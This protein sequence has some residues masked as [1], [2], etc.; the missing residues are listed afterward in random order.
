MTRLDKHPVMLSSQPRDRKAAPVADRLWL[1]L[2]ACAS[3]TGCLFDRDTY[4]DRKAVFADADGDGFDVASGDCDDHN[5][6]VRPGAVESC[7][8]VDQDCDGNIDEDASDTVTWFLDG[9]GDGAGDGTEYTEACDPPS[10]SW[11]SSGDDCDDANAERFPGATETPYDGID[12]DCDGSD[13]SDVDGDGFAG[14][15]DGSDCDDTDPEV[16]PEASESWGNLLT[17]NDCDSE[18]EPME[19]GYGADTWFGEQEE[20]HFGERLAALGDVDGDGTTEFLASSV[21][22]TDIGD[23]AGRVYIIGQGEPGAINGLPQVDPPTAFSGLGSSLSPTPDADAD[24]IVDFFIGATL[25]DEGAGG[26]YLISSGELLDA[27]VLQ[28]P[29]DALA[30]LEG[31]E[32]S[33]FFGS[34]TE[35]M[36]L[37]GDGVD[38]LLVGAPFAS[39]S[40]VREA[41][42]VYVFAGTLDGTLSA[43]DADHRIDGGIPAGRI[44]NAILDAGD[45]DGDGRADLMISGE[46]GLTAAVLTA[47]DL[48][49]D[50]EDS[51][52]IRVYDPTDAAPEPTMVGD[53]DGDGRRDMAIFNEGMWTLTDL[54]GAII[55]DL[56]PDDV[57]LQTGDDARFY[58]A[59]DLGDIDGD[60]KAETLVTIPD[61]PTDGGA[62]ALLVPGAA[63]AE[64]SR[65][66]ALELPYRAVPVRRDAFLGQRVRVVGDVDGDG[67]TDVA[68][69]GY[70]G[71]RGALNTGSVA[72]LPVP[73]E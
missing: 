29:R 5:P 30:V 45:Q 43:E 38:E 2:M 42:S 18:L 62:V 56:D 23:F 8:G 69:G 39:I 72:L 13:L 16:H 64:S 22:N 4:E 51:A 33:A 63:W 35:S 7:D 1:G 55:T 21:W 10:P 26:V 50:I 6:D 17:D 14:G 46:Y 20:A 15:V 37:D 9:D 24:G 19:E 27:Q 44:G 11:V 53:L 36:D 65:R 57:A 12:Q 52:L 60:G 41:G 54:A 49:G 28:A 34:M 68:I 73:G 67:R 58:Q 47:D 71:D 48:D 70:S 31:E 40:G 3:L 59:E 66:S 61:S 25:V 32:P